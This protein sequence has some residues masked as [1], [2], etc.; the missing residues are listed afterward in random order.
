M[1][2]PKPSQAT[3]FRNPNDPERGRR[4]WQAPRSKQY[5]IWLNTRTQQTFVR[6]IGEWHRIPVENYKKYN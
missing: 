2:G 4:W 6:G 3:F 1:S 5:D